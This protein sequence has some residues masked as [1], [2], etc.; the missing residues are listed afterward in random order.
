MNPAHQSS[1]A[2]GRPIDAVEVV[3]YGGSALLLD[4]ELPST[5]PLS[6]NGPGRL[7]ERVER[8]AS[9]VIKCLIV[10]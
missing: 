3:T 9:G 1:L 5:H 10:H 7:M 4:H 6:D 8:R 2:S